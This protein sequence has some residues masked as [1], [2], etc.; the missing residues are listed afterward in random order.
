MSH[1]LLFDI[2]IP[3]GHLVKFE[4]DSTFENFIGQF[5]A[6]CPKLLCV[7]DG[8]CLRY[9]DKQGAIPKNIRF[10][11]KQ[12]RGKS[13]EYYFRDIGN[14]SLYCVFGRE[15]AKIFYPRI[16]EVDPIDQSSTSG[17]SQKEIAP[18]N[19]SKQIECDASDNKSSS[20]GLGAVVSRGSLRAS[21]VL[22]LKPGRGRR[23]IIQAITS[24]KEASKGREQI[25]IIDNGVKFV[26]PNSNYPIEVK[27]HYPP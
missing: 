16:D 23:P 8:S 17:F 18:A 7:I 26:F 2:K 20:G 9:Y 25:I 12:R 14:E 3:E 19:E 21:G 11:Y 10:D 1:N 13:I 4:Q 24:G 15:A 5:Q 22:E 6:F 27:T